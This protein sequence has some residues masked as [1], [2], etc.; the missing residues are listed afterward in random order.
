[1]THYLDA[2]PTSGVIK[3]RDMMFGRAHAFRLDQGDVSFETPSAV[4]T[5]MRRALD[6]NQTHYVQTAGMPRLRELLAA[7]LRDTNGI[8]V[9]RPEQVFV[10]AG[11]M[12]ALYIAAHA[13]LEPGDEIILPDPVWTS[14]PGHIISTGATPVACPLHPLLDWR[15]DLDELGSKVTTRTRAVFL[16]SPHN[17]TGG[18]LTRADLE[19]IAALAIAHDLWVIS[20][21]A[22]EDIVYDDTEHVSIASLPD[23]F[24]RVLPIYTFSKSFAMTG[25]RLGYIAVR[26]PA[27]QARVDKLIGYTASNVSSVIQ[28]GGIGGLEASPVWLDTFRAELR[29]RRDYVYDRLKR[30]GG[31]FAGEPPKGAFYAFPRIADGWEPPDGTPPGGSRS[32][33]MAKHLITGANVGCI[34]GAEFGAGGEPYLRLCFARDQA[35]LEGALDAMESLLT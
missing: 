4:T 13:I 20:D 28:C 9:E 24:D 10:T 2:V 14:T 23:M 3:I 16:N 29:A 26:D 27:V 35:E 8:P 11:G 25:L 33:A 7:K 5:A 31:V 19:R 22:Y 34:P 15:Y 6:D 17:P 18:V 32:W 1:M 30:M 12:H 21:E